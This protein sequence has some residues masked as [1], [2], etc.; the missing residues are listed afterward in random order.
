MQITKFETFLC[1][2]TFPE[3][4]SWWGGQAGTWT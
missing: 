3:E 2:Y 1:S 4:K